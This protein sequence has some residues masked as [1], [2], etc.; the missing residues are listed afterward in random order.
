MTTPLRLEF[1]QAGTQAVPT[2]KA[3]VNSKIDMRSAT[4]HPPEQ[5]EVNDSSAL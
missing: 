1:A 4:A 5:F 2:L 3:P